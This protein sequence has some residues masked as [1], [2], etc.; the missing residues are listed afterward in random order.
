MCF[1]ASSLAE[2]ED[3]GDY[4]IH[5]TTFA[6]TLIPADVA[7]LHGIVRSENLIIVNVSIM[8]DETP[9]PASISGEV[10]NLLNQTFEM[11][12]AEVNEQDAIYY[13]GSHNAMEQDIL[14]FRILVDIPGK[15]PY[16]IAFLRRYD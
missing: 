4:R 16:P 1:S 2:A 7:K 14:R 15:E 3:H 8:K 13:L 12:F 11:E 5:Y 10:V 9:T 6:S